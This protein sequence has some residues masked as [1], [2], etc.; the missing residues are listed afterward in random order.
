MRSGRAYI[1]QVLGDSIVWDNHA[2]MPLRPDDD[3]FLGQLERVHK[4]GVDVITLNV[5]CGG[6]GI[7]EHI[8]MIAAFRRWIECNSENYCLVSRASDVAHAK[9]GGKLG[10]CFDIEGMD[11]LGGQVSLVEAYYSLGVRWML[12]AYNL[13]NQAGGGCM[14]EDGGLTTFGRSVVA[15]MNRVGMVPCG[16]HTGYKTARELIDVSSTPVIFSHSNPRSCWDH[17]RNI[18]DDLMIACAQRGGVIGINGIGIFLGNN[19]SKVST[20]VNHVE[21][22]LALVGD[23]HVGIALDYVFDDQEVAQFAA[24]NPE[25]FPSA[26]GYGAGMAMIAPWQFDTIVEELVRRGLREST[27]RKLM[28]ENHMRIAREVWR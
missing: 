5:G 23:E 2:C 7:E 13:A 3:S 10:V 21:H 14:E 18:P 8:R 24:A 28:G 12:V 17:P 11:A 1:S 25:M 26:A 15:E 19:D 9:S 16:S 20:F 27:L 6:Q 22:A 4:S